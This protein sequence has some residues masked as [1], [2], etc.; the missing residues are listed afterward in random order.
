VGLVVFH[1]LIVRREVEMIG[2]MPSLEER[3]MPLGRD[4]NGSR[5]GE[6]KIC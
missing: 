6:A 5:E 1:A 4:L 2:K 3:K